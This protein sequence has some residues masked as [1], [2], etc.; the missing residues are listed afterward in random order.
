M[1]A[2]TPYQAISDPTRRAILDALKDAGPLKAGEIAERF[3]RISRPAVSKHLRILRGARLVAQSKR[4]RE[5]WYRISPAP[6]A[7]VQHWI[8]DY[9]IFWQDRLAKLKDSVEQNE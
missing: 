8:K 3:A 5:V 4:G 6:L 9:E 2:H 1:L 7:Q